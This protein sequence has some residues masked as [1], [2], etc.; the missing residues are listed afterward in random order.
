MNYIRIKII[1]MT[2]KQFTKKLN[3]LALSNKDYS[4]FDNYIDNIKDNKKTLK[5]VDNEL[6]SLKEELTNINIDDIYLTSLD[7]ENENYRILFNDSNS[8]L[9]AL[10][11]SIKIFLNV[12]RKENEKAYTKIIDLYFDSIN[13][14]LYFDVQINRN[15]F[16]K[17]HFPIDLP[18][19]LRNIG[20]GKK[21]IIKSIKD[22][23][24]LLFKDSE[25]SYDLRFSVHSLTER[26]DIFS[27]MKDK[28]LIIFKDDFKIIQSKLKE[29]FSLGYENYSL[30]VDFVKKY[31]DEILKDD[32]LNELYKNKNYYE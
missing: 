8:D 29:W 5:N 17:F 9:E 6:N 1:I 22:F 20:L 11:D 2:F 26:N 16:N 14:N 30:D 25:D 18:P 7:K 3:E 10:T 13:H 28:D 12:I 15:N 21:I 32:F 23:N 27:F 19:F 31:K 24:Y 4:R